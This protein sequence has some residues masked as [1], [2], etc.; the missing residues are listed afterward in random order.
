MEGLANGVHAWVPAEKA[1]F[2]LFGQLLNP[3]YPDANRRQLTTK[4]KCYFLAFLRFSLYAERPSVGCR[5]TLYYN[6]GFMAMKR[7]LRK[8]LHDTPLP[9]QLD[10]A[11]KQI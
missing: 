1:N 3:I 7:V 9:P 4:D 6:T 11:T 10:W 2:T 8:I 5:N